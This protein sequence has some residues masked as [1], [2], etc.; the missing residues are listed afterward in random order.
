VLQSQTE[1]TDELIFP[2]IE[3]NFLF[4]LLVILQYNIMN[5]A[6]ELNRLHTI[7]FKRKSGTGYK[8][9]LNQSIVR[10][11]ATGMYTT[12]S[13]KDWDT[14]KVMQAPGMK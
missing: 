2:F 3:H 6:G 10:L 8:T 4:C 1:S 9:F 11:L 12:L 13:V 7:H 14:K 5:I